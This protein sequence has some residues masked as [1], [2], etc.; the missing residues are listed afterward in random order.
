MDMVVIQNWYPLD[1]IETKVTVTNDGPETIKNIVV[2][3]VV[4]DQTKKKKIMSGSEDSFSLKE[5]NDK[6]VTIDFKLMV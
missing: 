4:Y 1:T 2:K 5:G 3:W 6:T